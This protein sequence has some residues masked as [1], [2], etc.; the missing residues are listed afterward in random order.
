MLRHATCLHLTSS[1]DHGL[2]PGMITS[3][4]PFKMHDYRL[5]S[6]Q[7]DNHAV[8]GKELIANAD[9]RSSRKIV[10]EMCDNV[11]YTQRLSLRGDNL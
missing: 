9:F 3:S 6:R 7:A 1:N 4:S 11:C 8:G 5:S 10:S 2:V